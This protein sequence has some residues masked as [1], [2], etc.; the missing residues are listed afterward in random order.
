MNKDGNNDGNREWIE[1]W[2]E[3]KKKIEMRKV[4]TGTHERLAKGDNAPSNSSITSAN[5]AQLAAKPTTNSIT[6][7]MNKRR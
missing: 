5:T 7:I 3:K 1:S 4:N 6:S 2:S